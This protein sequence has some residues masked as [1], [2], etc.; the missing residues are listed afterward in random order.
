MTG[1]RRCRGSAR[2]HSFIHSFIHFLIRASS[3]G[4]C[5]YSGRAYFLIR[6]IVSPSSISSLPPRSCLSGGFTPRSSQSSCEAS[7]PIRSNWHPSTYHHQPP[8]HI[9]S[10]SYHSQPCPREIPQRR[11]WPISPP[12]HPTAIYRG[13]T[14]T[15]TTSNPVSRDVAGHSPL[16]PNVQHFHHQ[17]SSPLME[18]PSSPRWNHTTRRRDAVNPSAGSPRLMHRIPDVA[19]AFGRVFRG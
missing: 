1:V 10:P 5:Q 16:V 8:R 11:P 6:P 3:W 19:K 15:T 18:S 17:A 13:N 9:P 12:P 14:T 7:D 2:S 4:V